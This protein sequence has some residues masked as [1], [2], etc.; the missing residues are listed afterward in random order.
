MLATPPHLWRN[1]NGYWYLVW[2][3][4]GGAPRR[5]SLRTKSAQHAKVLLAEHL[6][7]G[8]RES[9]PSRLPLVEAAEAWLRDRER[10]ERR[11][12]RTTLAS[13]RTFV[14]R[15]RVAAPPQLLAD[16]IRPA[17]AQAVLDR[18]ADAWPASPETLRKRLTFLSMVFGWLERQELVRRNP[19]RSLEPPATRPVRKPAL[20][21]EGFRLLRAAAEGFEAAAKREDARRRRRAVVDLLDVLWLSGLRSVEAFRLTWEDVD[22]RR[23]RW[24]IRSPRN[25]GGERWEP[26]HDRLVPVLQRRRL[27]GADGPFRPEGGI[28]N[29][30]RRFK[31]VKPEFEGADLHSL[32]HGFVTRLVE[33][34]HRNAAQYLAGHRTAAMTE[35]YTHLR[36]EDFREELNQL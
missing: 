17:Q 12:A 1:P 28:R 10:P 3:E 5:R 4:A 31:A 22:L 11:L 21:E 36:G 8:T 13:Y 35:H 18:M 34:G 27:L 33:R 29:T 30:W 15:I 25:K 32:R 2:T 19:C 20:D 16:S 6:A 14:S 26:I 23:R 7:R 9:L 24:L